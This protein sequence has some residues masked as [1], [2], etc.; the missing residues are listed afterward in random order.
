MRKGS[1]LVTSVAVIK[2]ND[3]NVLRGERIYLTNDSGGVKSVLE[4]RV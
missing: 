3:Q 1:V 4:G 2:H